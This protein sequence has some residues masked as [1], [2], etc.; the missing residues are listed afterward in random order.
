MR[1]W[2]ELYAAKTPL[3]RLL[4]RDDPRWNRVSLSI[5]KPRFTDLKTVFREVSRGS[6]VVYDGSS[7]DWMPGSHPKT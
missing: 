4:P 2:N 5:K 7:L 1:V 3:S 6:V